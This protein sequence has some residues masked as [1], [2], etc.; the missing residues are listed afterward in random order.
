MALPPAA[1]EAAQFG[2]GMLA[3]L[4]DRDAGDQGHLVALRPLHQAPAARRKVV[5]DLGPVQAQPLKVDHVD[6][7]PL[8]GQ[9]PPAVVK[10]EEIGGLAGLAL[11]DIFERQARAARPVAAQRV[12]M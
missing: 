5:H 2:A 6:V 12:S 1:H 4:E 9:E 3:A 10:A 11:D 7:G 8:A